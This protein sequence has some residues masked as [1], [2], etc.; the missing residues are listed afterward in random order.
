M[1]MKELRGTYEIQYDSVEPLTEV[2]YPD[3]RKV[4]YSYDKAG[5]G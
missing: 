3:T 4:D 5:I 2:I 1:K